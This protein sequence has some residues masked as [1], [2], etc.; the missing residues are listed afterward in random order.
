MSNKEIQRL[1]ADGIGYGDPEARLQDDRRLQVLLA[2][3]QSKIGTRLNWLTFL[4]VIVGLLNAVALALQVW[5][6]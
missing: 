2:E 5:G 1:I 4:L 3:E 6:K